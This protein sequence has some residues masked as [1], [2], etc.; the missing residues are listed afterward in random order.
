MCN[1]VV[2]KFDIWAKRGVH[3]VW[4]D[5]AVRAYDQWLANHANDWLST[6]K[7]FFPTEIPIGG[8][9][10]ELRLCLMERVVLWKAEARRYVALQ[11]AEA[12]KNGAIP[13]TK[14]KRGRPREG[15][16]G[17]L[18]R[19]IK[20]VYMNK[21]TVKPSEL[22]ELPQIEELAKDYEKPLNQISKLLSRARE[23][24]SST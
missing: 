1:L 5:G 17:P 11:K 3:V 2:G 22:F 14:K 6:V 21:P 16:V 23:E 7:R 18:Y 4:G 9:L 15:R 13:Q 10:H 12:Q 19:R 8:L 24:L 20:E